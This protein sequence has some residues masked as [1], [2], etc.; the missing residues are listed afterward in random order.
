M[1]RKLI[2]FKD[3]KKDTFVESLD[4]VYALIIVTE[5]HTKIAIVKHGQLM[6][7]GDVWSAV[8]NLCNESIKEYLPKIVIEINQGNIV[9]LS[10]FTSSKQDIKVY[11]TE[12]TIDVS[13]N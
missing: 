5:L 13:E 7:D 4:C 8:S 9:D 12:T 10:Q 6:K 3:L 2:S 1:Q 11:V